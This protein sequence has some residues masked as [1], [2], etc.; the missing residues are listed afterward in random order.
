MRGFIAWGDQ[1]TR[2]DEM[3]NALWIWDVQQLS[4]F[5]LLLQLAPIR[6]NERAGDGGGRDLEKGAGIGEMNPRTKPR[7]LA[8]S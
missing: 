7:S 2:N 4:L 6:G 3:P 1:V 5:A 8:S